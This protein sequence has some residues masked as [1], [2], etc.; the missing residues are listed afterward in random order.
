MKLEREIETMLHFRKFLPLAPVAASLVT[1]LQHRH[2]LCGSEFGSS[3]SDGC[4]S[5]SVH[6]TIIQPVAKARAVHLPECNDQYFQ[7]VSMIVRRSAGTLKFPWETGFVAKV[8]GHN[9]QTNAWPF[10]EPPFSHSVRVDLV[11]Q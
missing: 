8:L 11:S 4:G 1:G 3:S 6:P 9:S 5:I 2:V 10:T 7:N